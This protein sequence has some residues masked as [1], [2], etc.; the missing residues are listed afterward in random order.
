MHGICCIV[1]VEQRRWFVDR[2]IL[3]RLERQ[4]IQKC[5]EWLRSPRSSRV[6]FSVFRCY[7]ILITSAD[8]WHGARARKH[9]HVR[10]A[11]TTMPATK[12]RTLIV[13]LIFLCNNECLALELYFRNHKNPKHLF[14]LLLFFCILLPD[15]YQMFGPTSSRLASS[16][17]LFGKS[18]T[19]FRVY[20]VRMK[21]G[22]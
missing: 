9:L 18:E 4:S 19:L 13:L 17:E 8:C 16:G 6:F 2:K 21:Q 22:V 3:K 1:Q 12:S 10:R 15:P 7:N 11:R 14:I 5:N 20:C